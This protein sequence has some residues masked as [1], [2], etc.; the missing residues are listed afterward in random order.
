MRS[1]LLAL[2]FALPAAA[3]DD[4]KAVI[5]KAVKAH[6]GAAALDKYAGQK[7]DVKGTIIA[8][9]M[10]IELAG[11]FLRVYPDKERLTANLN[12]GGMELPLVQIANGPAVILTVGG[13]PQSPEG[14]RKADALFGTY[15]VLL[16]GRLTPLLKG[17]PFTLKP[18]PEAAVGGRPAV[19]VVVEHTTYKPITLHFDTESGRLVRLT[20]PGKDMDGQDVERETVFADHKEVGGVLLPHTVTTSAGGKK[21]SVFTVQKYELLETVDES[22]FKPE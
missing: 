5:E 8:G 9:G 15:S 11:S 18:G 12:V 20:R 17:G 10:E 19:G 3:A 1:L 6:G 14:D 4:P 7:A 22:Q 13:N 21:V 16:A 2:A